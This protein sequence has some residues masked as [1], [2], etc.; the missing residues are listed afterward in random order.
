M[1]FLEYYNFNKNKFSKDGFHI[2]TEQWFMDLIGEFEVD[3]HNKFPSCYANHLFAND[4]TMKILDKAM[5]LDDD[6]SCGME[7]IDGEIDLD[8]NLKIENYSDIQT[9]YAI[10]SKIP[11]NED[12]PL[13]LITNEKVSDGVIILKYISEED[14]EETKVLDPIIVK[15]RDI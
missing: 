5:Q 7:L 6:E 12:E 13:L 1:F 15:E 14:T 4:S 8:T 10:G 3:F 2:D 11:E 9:T